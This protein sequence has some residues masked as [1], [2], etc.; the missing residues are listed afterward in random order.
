MV[1]L[2]Y[3]NA[4]DAAEFVTPLLSEI[5]TIKTNGDSE[6]F[7]LPDDTPT[8]A[9]EFALSATLVIFDYEENVEEIEALLH[10][11]DTRPAQVLVEAT[12]LQT[13]LNEANA[14]GIDFSILA[15]VNF[16]D[17]LTAGGPLGVANALISGGAEGVTP[18]DNRHRRHLNGRQHLRLRRIQGRR[19][20]RRHRHL[21][22]RPR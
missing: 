17:F 21:P 4:N 19:R 6:E 7:T 12:I 1:Q 9:D 18:A 20:P 11:L 15:D 5:G 2:N 14:F 13:T 16:T 22:P 10:Q 3:L 8:G